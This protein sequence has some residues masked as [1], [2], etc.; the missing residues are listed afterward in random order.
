M[1]TSVFGHILFENEE[2]I[3]VDDDEEEDEDNED[4]LTGEPVKISK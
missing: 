1:D 3:D 2:N 4:K